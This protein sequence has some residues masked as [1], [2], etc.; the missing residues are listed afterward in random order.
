MKSQK[1]VP[2]SITTSHN[3]SLKAPFRCQSPFKQTSINTSKNASKDLESYIL[4]NSTE[5]IKNQNKAR[6]SYNFQ[7]VDQFEQQEQQ[8]TYQQNS[9]CSNSPHRDRDT[10]IIKKKKTSNSKDK[11]ESSNN[12]VDEGRLTRFQQFKKQ[13]TKENVKPTKPLGNIQNERSMSNGAR[14][15]ELCPEDKAKIGELVKK[16]AIESKQKQEYAKKYE[17][18]KLEMGKRLK[19]LEQMS[20]LYEDER[21]QMKDKFTQSLQMLKQLKEDQS[22][23]ERDK[24][25]REEEL[26]KV[27]DEL[28]RRE[29]ELER[30][31]VQIEMEREEK[32]KQLSILMDQQQQQKY[33][34]NQSINESKQS[35]RNNQINQSSFKQNEMSVSLNDQTVSTL[36]EISDLK[37]EIVKLTTSLKHIKMSPD[38][39]RRSKE[40]IVSNRQL[41][42]QEQE[43]DNIEGEDSD[44][45][46][47]L[48][49][50][51]WKNQHKNQNQQNKV[52]RNLKES[53]KQEQE[54]IRK[55]PHK[56]SNQ[57]GSTSN[58]QQ[59]SSLQTNS[60]D[61]EDLQE[62]KI[63]DLY[64]LQDQLAKNLEITNNLLQSKLTNSNKKAT[65]RSDSALGSQR[66]SSR[67]GL[68]SSSIKK[69]TI[70]QDKMAKLIQKA[71]NELDEYDEDEASVQ[72]TPRPKQQAP[73][74]PESLSKREELLAQKMQ[75]FKEIQQRLNQKDK[76]SETDSDAQ[77]GRFQ[78]A[79]RD[80]NVTL[81][82]SKSGGGSFY[83]QLIQQQTQILH[84]QKQ[85]K[86]PT[87]QLNQS[88]PLNVT[89]LQSTLT[90][91]PQTIP[92]EVYSDEED[93][94]VYSLNQRS[95]YN[96]LQKSSL[97]GTQNTI[98]SQQ[99]M[100]FQPKQTSSSQAS[101]HNVPTSQTHLNQYDDSLF[102]IIDEI[103]YEQ[104]AQESVMLNQSQQSDRSMQ[105]S[106]SK[107]PNSFF[108]QQLQESQRGIQ[109]NNY[110]QGNN[111]ILHQQILPHQKPI[112]NY[113]EAP[114]QT[115]IQT[116]KYS[117][118]QSQVNQNQQMQMPAHQQQQYSYKQ[119]PFYLQAK[120]E[121]E[122]SQNQ[123]RFY[124]P[125]H[126]QSFNQQSNHDLGINASYSRINQSSYI[127]Q[128][129][130]PY[131]QPN[132]P[133][134]NQQSYDWQMQ[135]NQVYNGGALDQN[136]Y[137]RQAQFN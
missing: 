131:S 57:K 89:N 98:N 134:N 94:L 18:E 135:Q 33:Q 119:N 77:T 31:K 71:Q 130:Q 104:K 105:A 29:Q 127:Q 109:N 25:K 137:R 90:L 65:L 13:S 55:N 113:Y 103:E 41:Q 99:F 87:H 15:S 91:Q 32:N 7:E 129:P 67:S 102:N 21:D 28:I 123:S 42:Q 16:L 66:A 84:N 36:K 106:A 8:Q 85:G 51:W 10:V 118:G 61:R 69:L 37:N 124:T 82:Q 75:M 114:Q 4:R 107:R 126:Q 76:Q 100:S 9:S 70:D 40:K 92:S 93:D 46:E 79:E 88:Q 49:Q 22:K 136:G 125:S 58:R 133:T 5:S 74:E 68:Q 116:N 14:L 78:D 117:L 121:V 122:T 54:L 17:Q 52:Q 97:Q 38:Q 73:P 27:K 53:V 2:S 120:Q 59:R 3:T 81:S 12:K 26:Q 43:V 80:Q 24:Q 44:H 72:S 11:R 19:E 83:K 64:A 34:Q 132:Y 1:F 30:Q 48:E 60:L 39:N 111:Q 45:D 112:Q 62:M 47:S 128:E 35:Y 23:V 110:G 96:P 50:T 6:T 95:E 108:E 63:D 115:N 86:P 20:V 101:L 56:N